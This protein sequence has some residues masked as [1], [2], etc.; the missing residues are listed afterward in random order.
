MIDEN[1]NLAIREEKSTE[2][3]LVSVCISVYNG[4]AHLRKCLDSVISQDIDCM[5]IVLVND[6]STDSTSEIMHEYRDR[7]PGI[8]II[9]QE[10]RGLAQ[11]RWTGVKNSNGR[12]ITFLDVDDYL[13]EGAY[14]TILQFMAGT[15]ADI[16][17][18][19]TIREDCYSKSPY[20]GIMDAGQVLADYFDGASI[21]VNYW[22]RW[23]KRELFSESVFPV[24]ISLHEDVYGFPC[25]L[26]RADTIAYIGKP[27]H[28]HTRTPGSIMNTHNEKKNTRE[29]FE[30]QKLLLLSIPH[31]A[32]NIGQNVIDTDYKES[33]SHYAARIYR[34][35]IFMAVKDVSYNE[36]L[37]AIIDTLELKMSRRELER[38]IS[39]NVGLQSRL[40]RV[41]HLFGL[42]DGYLLYGLR[43]RLSHLLPENIPMGGTCYSDCRPDA[44]ALPQRLHQRS[45]LAGK[46]ESLRLLC[47][48]SGQCRHKLPA[49]W[50]FDGNTHCLSAKG[51]L[52]PCGHR[53]I[54]T[55]LC[56]QVIGPF[57]I[58]QLLYLFTGY[59]DPD[60]CP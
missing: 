12:Y 51:Y 38:F 60:C 39:Q 23:F 9:E 44:D 3:P 22:L 28:V 29:Y 15:R 33:F 34:N 50:I 55:E 41:I 48:I 31:I 13:L 36:K 14:K 32:S 21:P 27:L 35:F 52:K 56:G 58:R 43:N 26:N 25:L 20:T 5:E 4:E 8:R 42:R 17:E 11:G 47:H 24:G 49:L 7:F 19:Q 40:N 16:Y 18:F 37:D 57:T 46:S 45:R 10:N 1:K 2:R 53:H 54:L 6:G 59:A 30:K